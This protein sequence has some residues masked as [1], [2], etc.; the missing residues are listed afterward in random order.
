MGVY[1]IDNRV[2]KPPDLAISWGVASGTSAAAV[3]NAIA[4]E[5]GRE[6]RPSV[7]AVLGHVPQPKPQ[8]QFAKGEFEA[9]G[10]FCAFQRTVL[11]HGGCFGMRVRVLALVAGFEL[12]CDGSVMG[13]GWWDILLRYLHSQ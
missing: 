1:R 12:A 9:G 8:A 7:R 5:R 6:D 4:R 3:L 11:L 10:P 2:A 13:I